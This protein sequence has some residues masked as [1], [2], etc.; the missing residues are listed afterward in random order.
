M[1]RTT[2]TAP[3]K[4]RPSHAPREKVRIIHTHINAVDS[5]N[6]LDVLL[7]GVVLVGAAVAA[8][9]ILQYMFR[10][11]YQSASWVDSDMFS[12]IPGPMPHSQ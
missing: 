2:N 7:D 9:G 11:G 10:W 4:S 6:Q 3:A 1:S 8:Y 12:S 5:R